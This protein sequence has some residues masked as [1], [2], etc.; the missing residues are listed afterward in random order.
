MVAMRRRPDTV[1]AY[2]DAFAERDRI[3]ELDGLNA[4]A[5]PA[6]TVVDLDGWKLRTSR[7]LTR[8]ANSVWPRAFGD[9]LGLETKLAN[10]ERHYAERGLPTIFQVGPASQPKGLDRALA[11]RGYERSEPVEVRTARIAD[12]S[13][14]LGATPTGLVLAE[15]PSR[16]WLDAWARVGARDEASRDLAARMLERV[17]APSVYALLEAG[18]EAVAVARAVLDGGWLGIGDV[19]TAARWRRRGAARTLLA[20]L[21]DWG[22]AHA[23]EQAWLAVEA[24][25][26]PALRLYR[27]AG[28]RPAY[29]Y[30]YR[31]LPVRRP[32]AR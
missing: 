9:R 21:A 28:F 26:A 5:W 23:A 7:G 24:G 6:L 11:A 10:V 25:N 8:R 12:L 27:E 30:R 31:S 32:P 22:A 3:Y 15:T 4:R 2:R 13:G 29:T 20:V 16:R 1:R 18:G 17:P 19:V 14:G